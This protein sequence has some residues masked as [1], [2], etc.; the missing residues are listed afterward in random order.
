MSYIEQLYLSGSKPSIGAV[1][2]AHDIAIAETATGLYRTAGQVNFLS[3][4]VTGNCGRSTAKVLH[5]NAKVTILEA[6]T[7]EKVTEVAVDQRLP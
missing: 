7:A 2:A 1:G 4:N 5:S 6:R 3:H